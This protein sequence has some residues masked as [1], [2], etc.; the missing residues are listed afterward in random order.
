MQVY[1]GIDIVE[2]T[3]IKDIISRNKGFI[4]DIFTERER[5]YCLSK[6]ESH[7][8]F[9]GRFAAKEAGLKALGLG[10]SGDGIDKT[11]QEIEITSHSSGR[12]LL[13][14]SG[15]AQ[16]ISR[17]KNITQFTVSISHSE[18]YAVATVILLSDTNPKNADIAQPH[19]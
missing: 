6:K 3:R 13:T 10:M 8:H 12:P 5:E 9:A 18:N 11:L 1:Q 4:T 17:K 14:M 2:I 7:I 19:N 16:K 15:R